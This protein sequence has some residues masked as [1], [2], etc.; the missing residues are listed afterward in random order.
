MVA[1]TRELF[2]H[3]YGKYAV[4]TYNFLRQWVLVRFTIFMR[5]SSMAGNVDTVRL[6]EFE[7]YS[8][9]LHG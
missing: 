8:K 3:A 5:R 9:R 1:S 4:G 2:R 7:R 6:S